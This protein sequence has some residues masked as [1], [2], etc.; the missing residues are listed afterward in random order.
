MK[1]TQLSSAS[2]KQP[3]M[4]RRPKLNCTP[5]FRALRALSTQHSLETCTG[6][7]ARATDLL[8][9]SHVTRQLPSHASLRQPATCCF[10]RC[11]LPWHKIQIGGSAAT[12]FAL[13]LTGA[14][15]AW[16]AFMPPCVLRDTPIHTLNW[17]QCRPVL[18]AWIHSSASTCV[19]ECCSSQPLHAQ[20]P[21]LCAAGRRL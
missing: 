7:A 5:Y 20:T 8:N 1:H 14:P 9:I 12:C 11:S 16:A 4:K 3:V 6:S 2:R 18:A 10:T 13:H 21:R 15:H 17:R 19:P